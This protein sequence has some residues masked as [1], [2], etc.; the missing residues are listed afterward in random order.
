M[1]FRSGFYREFLKKIGSTEERLY[2]WEA[3]SLFTSISK[4]HEIAFGFADMP[5]VE[6]RNAKTIVGIGSDFL[7]VGTSPIYHAK[8]YSQS[9]SF[10]NGQKG[11]FIQFESNLSLTGAAADIRHLI[12]PGSETLVALCLLKSLDE[13]Q[14]SKG[15]S[16]ERLR[17][18]AV[19][20]SQVDTISQAYNK[21][22]MNSESLDRKSTRLN[23]SHS[24]QSRMPSSA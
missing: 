2:T 9:H 14:A 22:G 12:K 23:S 6:L 13:N 16:V 18:K 21:V 8:G 20:S 19:L 11:T 5:R 24:Q 4:A 17:I 15:S 3:N 7:D 10:K 1:L